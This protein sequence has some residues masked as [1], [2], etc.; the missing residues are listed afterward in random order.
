MS[1]SPPWLDTTTAG[2]PAT[3]CF[4]PLATSSSQ[5]RPGFS[6]TNAELVIGTPDPGRKVIAHGAPKRVTSVAVKGRAELSLGWAELPHAARAR[7]AK[8]CA[9]RRVTFHL[10]NML[11]EQHAFDS[12]SALHPRVSEPFQRSEAP[13]TG[14]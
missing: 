2:A 12:M 10:R 6:V 4:C 5:T 13:M 3:G 14:G 9:N 8:A 1:S 11:S 7:R